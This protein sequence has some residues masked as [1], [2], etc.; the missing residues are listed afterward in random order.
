[1]RNHPIFFPSKLPCLFEGNEIAWEIFFCDDAVFP[2][3]QETAG[4]TTENFFP[5][6]DV[7]SYTNHIKALVSMKPYDLARR[8]S[9]ITP[10]S[11][12]M[13]VAEKCV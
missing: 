6:I 1:M 2:V 11:V 9:P 13:K 8:Q 12:D 7:I 10:P 3:M 4:E 5:A